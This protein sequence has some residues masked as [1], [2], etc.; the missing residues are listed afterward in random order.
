MRKIITYFSQFF[1]LGFLFVVSACKHAEPKRGVIVDDSTQLPV[2]GVRIELYLKDVKGDSLSKKI[3]SDENGRF[4]IQ[5]NLP[6]DQTFVL[7]KD[8]YIS[9]VSGFSSQYDTIRLERE[10]K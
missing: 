2:A 4:E 3:Y 5:E 10:V 8:G 6:A 1:F 7:E 9:F